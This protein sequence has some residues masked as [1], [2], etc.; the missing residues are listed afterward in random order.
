MLFSELIEQAG[1]LKEGYEKLISGGPMMGFSVFTTRDSGYEDL[2]R[3][4]CDDEG[5]SSGGGA[6]RLHQLRTLRKRMS[7]ASDSDQTFRLTRITTKKNGLWQ[8][9]VWSAAS[10]APVRLCVR[11]RD[12]WRSRSSRCARSVWRTGR[13]RNKAEVN[14]MASKLQV[15]SSPHIRSKVTTSKIMRQSLSLCFRQLFS[16]CG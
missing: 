15:S 13:K 11:P 2:R 10:A 8:M 9:T 14:R 3:N 6:V 4:S 12:S 1:G 5:R 7:G 16:A